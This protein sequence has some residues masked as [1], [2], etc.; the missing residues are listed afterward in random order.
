MDMNFDVSKVLQARL[1]NSLG[2]DSYLNIMELAKKIDV[3]KDIDFQ[4]TFNGFY[5]VRRNE[6]WR[7]IYYDYF[8]IMKDKTPSFENIITYLYEKTGYVEPSFSSKMLATLDSSKPIWDRYVVENLELKLIGKTSEEKLANA[9]ETY[10]VIEQ[11]YEEFLTTQKAE[12][13]IQAFDSALPDYRMIH[14]IKKVDTILW[15][16]R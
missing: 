5:R 12:E 6:E 3:S 14:P 2:L 8:E 16:I 4:R 11:W 15:S 10:H 9:I 13:C 7:K 1:A